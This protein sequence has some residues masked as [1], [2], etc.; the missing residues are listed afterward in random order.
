[1]KLLRMLAASCA[2]LA[3]SVPLT[4]AAQAI[5]QLKIMI[6]ASPGGGFDQ[7]GRALGAALQAT[8]AVKSLQYE[9]KGGAGGT[10]GLAQFVNS[11]RG[12]PK[13]LVVAGMVTVGA[14]HLNKSPVSLADVTPLARLLAEVEVIAVPA[15]S[16]I[17]SIKDLAAALKTNPG[18]VAFSGGSAGGTDH[19]VA[20]LLAREAGADPA[21]VNYIAYTGG[22]EAMTA[23]LGG[24][25]AAGISGLAE[26]LPQIK[27]GRLRALAVTSAQR[28]PD[29][30]IPTLR[31]QGI[32]LEIVNWRGVFAPPGLNDAQRDALAKAVD[33]A[34]KTP[35]WKAALDK[36]EWTD[37][38][39]PA[40]PFRTFVE[41]ED[42][43]VGSIVSSLAMGR[44]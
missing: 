14:A 22:A 31:E 34:V 11:E 13:A 6:P 4:A 8:G 32:D 27:S 3:G 40:A 39:L 10:I 17:Q 37:F 29:V 20:G 5:D 28:V 18:S 33:A 24:H 35:Q 36:Q 30:D 43:R 15:N 12:N 16:K 25:V 44:K 41:Q 2:L 7:T 42:K 1:M 26:F 21:K 9:N 23:L 38:Y 19:L